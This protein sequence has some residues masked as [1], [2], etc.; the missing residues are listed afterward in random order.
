MQPNEI[1][2]IIQQAQV[3]WIA[4]DAAGFADLFTEDGEFIVPGDRWVGRESIRKIA[5]EFAADY[6]EVDIEIQRLIIDGDQ[7]V[8]E[9]H[10]EDKQTASGEH[11]K[12]DD[13]IVVDFRD[14]QICRWREYID[15]QV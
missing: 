3:A 2:N 4:G 10:W 14:G 6:S 7:A 11:N 15:S 1:R 12:A 13:A 8:V 5:A 9:W